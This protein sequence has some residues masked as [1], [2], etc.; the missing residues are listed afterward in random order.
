MKLLN[1]LWV[2]LFCFSATGY[3]QVR[4]P[5]DVANR[6]QYDKSF[7]SYAREMTRYIKNKQQR[8][9]PGTPERTGIDKQEKYL[10][11][12]LWYLEGRQ[13]ENGNIT[14]YT[15]KTFRAFNNYQ[16]THPLISQ[17]ATAFGDWSL[18]GPTVNYPAYTQSSTGIGRADRI[19]FHP[20][21][22]NTIFVGTPSS[23]IFKSVNGGDSWFNLNAYMPSLGVSGLVVSWENANVIYALTGDGDSNLGD[24]GFVQGFDYIRPS[25]G[26]LKSIDGGVTWKQTGPLGTDDGFYVGY[27]LIQH[28]TTS[29]MLL[30][31]TSKGIYRTNDGGDS[32][33]R[34]TNNERFY[35]IEWKPQSFTR[36]YACTA[37]SFYISND[38]GG[39]F[40]LRNANLDIP[41]DSSSRMAL[42]VSPANPNY[43]Y[44][45]SAFTN[46]EG[47]VVNKGVYKSTNSGD[48][49]IQF[50]NEPFLA[51]STPQY[52][53]TM[54]VAPDNANLL[55][56]GNLRIYRSIN[57]GAFTVSSFDWT[58]NDPNY[59]HADVHDMAYNPLNKALYVASDGG[60]YKSMDN[61]ATYTAKYTGFSAT[62][63]FHF[64]VSTTDPNFMMGGAQDNGGLYREGNYV[65]FGKVTGGDGYDVQFYNGSNTQA[66]IS[67]NTSLYHFDAA[68]ST[69]TLKSNSGSGWFRTIA[70]SYSNSNLVFVSG[71]DI[72]RTTN[73][74]S[75]WS[76]VSTSRNGRWAMITCP[77]NSNRVY[78]AGGISFNDAP[79]GSD[80]AKTLMRS[81]NQGGSWLELQSKP[82]FPANI[83]KITGIAVSPSNSSQ[84]WITMGGF[85]NGQK[86]Y[87]SNDA[88]D[89]WSNLTGTL[90]NIPVNCITIDNN[91]DAYIGTD[92]GV[93]FK[94]ALMPDWQPFYNGMPALPVTELHIR[95]GVLY[96]S[97]FGR[98]I[99]KSDVHG[100]CPR[101]LSFTGTINGIRFY[102]AQ[103]IEATNTLR[104]GLGTEFYLRAQISVTLSAGFRADGSTGEKFRA[105]TGNCGSGG[106]PNSL[107][108]DVAAWTRS[109]AANQLS[110][111]EDSGRTVMYVEMPFDGTASIVAID[112]SGELKEV[113][114]NNEPVRTGKVTIQFNDRIDWT[115]RCLALLIDGKVRGYV[116]R[117]Q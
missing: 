58:S 34:I 63:F 31:A 117:K 73:G 82:G 80:S 3:S 97:T 81:D 35:D 19:A 108:A 11:R 8:Y 49:M 110:L 109:N 5:A 29:N 103:Q 54:A 69:L 66:Y 30:A 60:V 20:T 18:V 59:V 107:T 12:Q 24:Y 94:S 115:N 55:L 22:P 86:V 33:H 74:G 52:M 72:Y 50:S 88:G 6:L 27:K 40:Q 7:S 93:F 45:F 56:V 1:I 36:L 67:V 13:D 9:A 105:W 28:P 114:F 84:V 68:A 16:T 41:I 100:D 23:G 102:E 78:A 43:V 47:N 91:L 14:R 46:S 113:L 99:W 2:A 15:E 106:L 51:T 25:I 53:L 39:S 62:Q 26:V 32:W 85:T 4:V 37:N 87:Y 92:A 42:A 111:T 116:S 17:Q 70:M 79:S 112:N 89:N 10:A 98:G 76:L 57:G 64:D 101:L 71:D 44:L 61:G 38:G 96:A 90:P 83:T 65:S 75:N 104:G 95:N 21:D 48:N 77:S